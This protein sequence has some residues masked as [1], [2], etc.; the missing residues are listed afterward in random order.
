[1][2]LHLIS[3]SSYALQYRLFRYGLSDNLRPYVTAGAGP[4]VIMTT[5]A[6]Q[7]FFGAF[8]T[9]KSKVVPGGFVGIGANFGTDPKGNFGASLR[10]FII[11]YPGS[12]QST[13][14]ESL[15]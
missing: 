1:M 9:A 14:T 5:D 11:P 12:V 2:C 10:Y 6:Q 7:E 15:T 4:T 8:G 13:S 3:R